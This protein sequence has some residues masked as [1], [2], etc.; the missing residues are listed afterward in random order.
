[1][2]DWKARSY[3]N[4]DGWNY[5]QVKL[6]TWY[7]SGF[8]G[9]ERC[10]WHYTA[11]GRVDFPIKLTRLVVELRDRVLHLTDL[12]PVPDPAIRLRDLGAS[13]EWFRL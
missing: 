13:Y 3:I 4:F 9:P 11:E 1:V 5:L 2:V 6:L 12:V 8:Y 10:D 7:E